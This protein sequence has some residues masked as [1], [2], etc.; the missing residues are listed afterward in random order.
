[1]NQAT[2]LSK[3]GHNHLALAR[4]LDRINWSFPRSGSEP[5][6]IHNLHWFAGN[7]IPQIPAALIE[8]LSSPGDLVLDPFGGSGTTVIEAARLGRRSIYS[9]SVTACAFIA[10]AKVSV[11]SCPPKRGAREEAL[12]ALTWSH[13]CYS[14]EP[15]IHGEGS[16][17]E[18][19][20]WF[21]PN[22]LGQLRYIWKTIERVSDPALG[23]LFS[24]LL[25]ACASTGG[26]I[27]STGGTRKH[28]WGWIAD[29]VR[30]R[31]LI[32][33]DAVAGF[34]ERLSTLPESS[35]GW[36]HRPLILQADARNLPIEDSSVDLIVTS[37]PYISVIDYVRAQRLLYVWMNWPFDSDRAN[38]IGARYK[39]RRRDATEAYLR[40][41]LDVWTE[42]SR[43]LRPGG[44]LAVVLGESRAFPGVSR[45]T[46]EDAGTLLPIIWGP[47]ERRAS[48]RRVS[49][50]LG[51]ESY[52]MVFV[53][54][55]R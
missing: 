1:V 36:E 43:V 6:S 10:N 44:R 23:L 32:E 19:S 2:G 24:D 4:Q 25:F 29:N 18:L 3:I 5:Y 7:F 39:R 16:A 22:T 26:S 31:E 9:D 30:P 37:P 11:G 46:M 12:A 54:E 42:L 27:T 13:E 8:L 38:E 17:T 45:S 55:K 52:E 14:N 51:R 41:M 49:D 28:H 34:V 21:T 15:G 47:V 50:R 53:A 33:H 35:Q 40:Q 48:R 20:D